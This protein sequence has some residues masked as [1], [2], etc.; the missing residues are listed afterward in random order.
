MHAAPDSLLLCVV[1][2]AVLC[3]S[4]IVG[5]LMGAMWGASALPAFMTEPVLQFGPGSQG[6]ERPSF[7]HP[8]QLPQLFE[9]LWQAART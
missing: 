6:R 9:Q 3:S 1:R 2:C 5:G 4:A 7:L 8:Q